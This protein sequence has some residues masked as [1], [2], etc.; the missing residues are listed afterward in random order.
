[1][2]QGNDPPQKVDAI[3]TYHFN[4]DS[5]NASVQLITLQMHLAGAGEPFV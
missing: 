4:Y 5:A 2:T 3:M 1:M